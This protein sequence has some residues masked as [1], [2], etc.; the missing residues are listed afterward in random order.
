MKKNNKIKNIYK[1]R[2][3]PDDDSD[4]IQEKQL[5][6]L[7]N[8]MSVAD[9]AVV[10][11][12]NQNTDTLTNRNYDDLFVKPDYDTTDIIDKTTLNKTLLKDEDGVDFP[13]NEPDPD[14]VPHNVE[15]INELESDFESD[16][17]FLT[18]YTE[19]SYSNRRISL[20]NFRSPLSHSS[21]GQGPPQ[22]LLTKTVQ[23]IPTFVRAI[24]YFQNLLRD[25]SQ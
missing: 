18:E 15:K 19:A 12:P 17:D 7:Q 9:Y 5:G 8:E 13:Q 6:A 24:S 1:T 2:I 14:Q 4:D 11:N 22:I 20:E 21:I 3:N 25:Y 23:E 16:E 10:G